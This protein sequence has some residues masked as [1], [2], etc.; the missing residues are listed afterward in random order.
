M[1]NKPLFPEPPPPDTIYALSIP[2][3]QTRT[4]YYSATPDVISRIRSLCVSGCTPARI[5]ELYQSLLPVPA[6]YHPPS[7]TP[8]ASNYQQA[9][10]TNTYCMDRLR[11]IFMSGTGVCGP[12]TMPFTGVYSEPITPFSTDSFTSLSDASKEGLPLLNAAGVASGNALLTISKTQEPIFILNID[13]PDICDMVIID[14]TEITEWELTDEALI[15]YASEMGVADVTIKI[16]Y[17]FGQL[18]FLLQIYQ[19]PLLT[20]TCGNGKPLEVNL[21][22]NIIPVPTLT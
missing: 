13:D 21:Y 18:R 9:P 5:L 15:L 8:S 4:Y 10:M 22:T 1:G 16:S 11:N 20:K 14:L 12:D 2:D 19:S 3:G 7:A 17:Q 6:L